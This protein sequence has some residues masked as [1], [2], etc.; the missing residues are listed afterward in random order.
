MAKRVK[1]AGMKLLLDFHYSDYWADP[2]KQFMPAAW[3]NISFEALKDSVYNYTAKVIWALKQQGT[4]PDM[5]QIGNEINHGMLWP[6]GQVNKLDGLAQLFKSGHDAVLSVDPSII[7]MLHIALGGQ[8]DETKFFLDNM[9][10]RGV[11]F[12]VIGQSYYP[13]WHGTTDDLKNNLYDMLNRYGKDLIVVEYSSKKREVNDIIFN[14]PRNK[15]KGSFIWEPLNTWEYIFDP[16]GR[17]NSLIEIY[18]ELK[19]KYLNY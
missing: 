9:I 3:Q 15:G 14:L 4:T 2:G 8:N 19:R 16:D 6:E 18:D 11:D 10:K 7:I 17:S 12:D 5:V 1:K 13:Q